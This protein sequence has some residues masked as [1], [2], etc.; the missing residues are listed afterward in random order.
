MISTSLNPKY[1][2]DGWKIW[3]RITDIT[4][5]WKK[6]I[7]GFTGFSVRE[8]MLSLYINRYYL[9]KTFLDI[10]KRI[11]NTIR[12]Y[13]R[14][15]CIIQ[16]I[17]HELIHVFMFLFDRKIFFND[18]HGKEFKKI[19]RNLYKIN[20]IQSYLS[21]DIDLYVGRSKVVK[22]N[23]KIGGNAYILL[24][25]GSYSKVKILN[26]PS[27]EELEINDEAEIEVEFNGEKFNFPLTLVRSPQKK[28]KKKQSKKNTILSPI[29]SG[30]K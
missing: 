24:E 4:E 29:S 22:K 28:Y 1:K 17:E 8:K 9:R 15:Q 18:E 14:L 26:L 3:F 10:N 13:D 7:V 20:T 11:S 30:N 6:D 21:E 27:D 2:K 12:C 25:D 5:G 16:T 19:N 23:L